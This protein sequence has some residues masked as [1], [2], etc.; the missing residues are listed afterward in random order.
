MQQILK[1]DFWDFFL[2]MFNIRNCFICR[3]SDSTVPE[4]ALI[5]NKIKFSLYIGKFRVEQLQSHIWGRAS[6]NIRKCENMSPYMRRPLVIYDFATAPLWI[7]LYMRKIWFSFL[8][9]CWDRTRTVSNTALA[10]RHSYHSARS[11]LLD[12]AADLPLWLLGITI[13][14]ILREQF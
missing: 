4:D 10:V 6:Q 11:H 2:F 8:S 5:K 9:V 1:G 12:D 13:M 14:H 7:S 3:P